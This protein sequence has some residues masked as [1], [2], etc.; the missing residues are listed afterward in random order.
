MV[1]Y[2]QLPLTSDL[3][4]VI[5]VT[6]KEETMKYIFCILCICCS[7]IS[8][9]QADSLQKQINEQVWKP[10]I[11]TFNS[12]D[13]EGF[14]KVHSP[15]LIRVMSDDDQVLDYEDYLRPVD[16]SAK[17]KWGNWSHHIELRFLQRIASNGKAFETGYYKTTAVNAD[18]KEKRVSY[19]KFHVLLR[20]E[21]GEWKILMDQDA[22]EDADEAKFLQAA[23]ID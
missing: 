9:S 5:T 19:G 2:S 11:K 6:I 21:N 20:K 22:K 14:R 13:N 18:T 7:Y 10:F 1:R 23:P 12:E 17:A 15:E 8:F 4:A 16:D 3:N